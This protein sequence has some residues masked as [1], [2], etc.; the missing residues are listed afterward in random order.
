[1]TLNRGEKELFRVKEEN[2]QELLDYKRSI[3]GTLGGGCLTTRHDLI[4]DEWVLI[5]SDRSFPEAAMG[6]TAKLAPMM[7][8]FEEYLSKEVME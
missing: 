4:T 5:H 8:D 7:D 6:S 3:K 2:F 1:M